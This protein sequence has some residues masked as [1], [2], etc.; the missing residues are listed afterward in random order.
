MS[1]PSKEDAAPAT[2]TAA[3]TA[4]SDAAVEVALGN[5]DAAR[6]AAADDVAQG[7]EDAETRAD[8][9]TG[10]DATHR[11]AEHTWHEGKTFTWLH[12]GVRGVAGESVACYPGD[13]VTFL[14]GEGV[15]VTDLVTQRVVIEGTPDQDHVKAALAQADA[16]RAETVRVSNL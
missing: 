15:H 8:T 9:A 7:R 13:E 11:S 1:T 3:D 14:P 4:R 6:A 10:D 5:D 2:T 16:A 12:P